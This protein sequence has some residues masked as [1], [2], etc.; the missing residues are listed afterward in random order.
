MDSVPQGTPEPAEALY[1]PAAEL[2]ND[3]ID[4]RPAKQA[5]LQ[6]VETP[7]KPIPSSNRPSILRS[8]VKGVTLARLT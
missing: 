6:S 2:L 5:R 1:G 4:A 8:V 7:V 3:D